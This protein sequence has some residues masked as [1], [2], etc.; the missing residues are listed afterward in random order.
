MSSANEKTVKVINQAGPGGFVLFLAYIGAAIYF[1]QKA[2]DGFWDVVLGLLQAMIWPVY[3]VF[4]IL[5]AL[6]A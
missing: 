5:Q 3:V 2:G 4:H 1:V 6:G